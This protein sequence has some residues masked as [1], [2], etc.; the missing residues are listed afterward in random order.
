AGFD[1]HRDDPLA[2]LDLSGDCFRWMTRQVKALARRCCN[3]RI[4]TM[5]EGGY[6]LPALQA[7]VLGHLEVLLEDDDPQQLGNAA[8]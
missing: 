6:D 3:G 2:S 1:A 4:V 7:S 5:L 8:K